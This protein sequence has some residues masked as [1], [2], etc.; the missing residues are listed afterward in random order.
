MQNRCG[1]LELGRKAVESAHLWIGMSIKKND[2][3]SVICVHY[4]LFSCSRRTRKYG[5]VPWG[6]SVLLF[7]GMC[8]APVTSCPD[9]GCP[10]KPPAAPHLSS[11]PSAWVPEVG[12][13]L[14]EGRHPFAAAGASQPWAE[15]ARLSASTGARNAQFCQWL[16]LLS[17][18]L[19]CGSKIR[20]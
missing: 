8:W 9:M 17:L 12:W 20:Y 11:S 2:K 13:V 16:E 6:L 3:N 1:L 15:Q 5:G 18:G 19:T 7:V 14:L 4:H 10:P